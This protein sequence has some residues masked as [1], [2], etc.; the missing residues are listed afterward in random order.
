MSTLSPTT[1]EEPR[2]D[3][4]RLARPA[5]RAMAALSGAVELDSGLRDLVSLRASIINGCAY[6]VDMHT[7]DARARGESEQRLH[8]IATWHEAPFF[9]ERERAAL[10]LTDEITLIAGTHVTREA[11]EAARG[12]FPDEELTQLIWAIIAINAWNRLA[13]AT[14]MRPGEYTP[15]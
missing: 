7:L 6:C 8:A 3:V 14:R 1:F 9:S 13:V 4:T 5:Y 12:H 11:F 15:S 2:L 10:R